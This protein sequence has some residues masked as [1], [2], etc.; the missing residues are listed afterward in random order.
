MVCGYTVLS[1]DDDTEGAPHMAKG[2]CR[3][4]YLI[5]KDDPS[6]HPQ[7]TWYSSWSKSKN[8]QNKAGLYIA[9]LG[10]NLLLPCTA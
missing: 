7:Y 5:W 9:H 3:L 8:S 4:K 1:I 6:Y 2:F 10:F